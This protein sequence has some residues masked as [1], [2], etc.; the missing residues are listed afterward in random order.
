MLHDGGVLGLLGLFMPQEQEL[1]S[2]CK[3]DLFLVHFGH[4]QSSEGVQFVKRRISS[5]FFADD[6]LLLASS[7]HDFPHVNGR[8][9]AECE[10][11]GRRILTFSDWK[12]VACPLRVGGE[13]LTHLDEFKYLGVFFRSEGTMECE[14]ERRSVFRTFAPSRKVKL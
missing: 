12:R 2:H 3:S 14:L 5:L 11:G 13:V 4:W 6:V 8:F 1:G 7:I 10:M 9:A